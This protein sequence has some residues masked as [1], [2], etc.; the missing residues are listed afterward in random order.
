VFPESGLF[1]L[2]RDGTRSCRQE[3]C[4]KGVEPCGPAGMV[5]L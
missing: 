4:E 2:L 1:D 5:S 3:A